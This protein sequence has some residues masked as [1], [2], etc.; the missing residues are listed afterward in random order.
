MYCHLIHKNI[1]INIGIGIGIKIYMKKTILCIIASI[2]IWQFTSLIV[3]RIVEYQAMYSLF[4]SKGKH[5]KRLANAIVLW[6][7]ADIWGL[8]WIFEILSLFK[9]DLNGLIENCLK[10]IKVFTPSYC[11]QL[12]FAI[13]TKKW[14]STIKYR[15]PK[16]NIVLLMKCLLFIIVLNYC[17]LY[18]SIIGSSIWT[19]Y[20]FNIPISARVQKLQ[21]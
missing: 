5:R 10:N 8:F 9:T 2:I 3:V 4:S 6:Y 1:V 20:A 7:Y 16:S 17:Y 12:P 21:H 19:F 15:K 11:I 18:N 14:W 13:T